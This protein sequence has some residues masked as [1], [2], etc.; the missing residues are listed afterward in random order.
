[1][2]TNPT[3]N[4]VFVA[5][6]VPSGGF[7]ADFYRFA[8]GGASATKLGTYRVMS[9]SPSREATVTDRP[10]IDGGDNGWTMIA[11]KIEGSITVQL[12]TDA[13]PTLQAGDAFT[14]SVIF[15]DPSG[16]AL[17][18][19]CVL[20]S[21]STNIDTSARAQTGTARVNKQATSSGTGYNLTTNVP[22]YSA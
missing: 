15:R 20:G 17:P 9:F 16:T 13:S 8:T 14:T 7:F 2:T 4:Q 6:S 21:M 10:D 5:N 11:G 3:P 12:A 18:I 19:M 22:E 1:M